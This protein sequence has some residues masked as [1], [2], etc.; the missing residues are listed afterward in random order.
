MLESMNPL[1]S[2]YYVNF[3]TF[4]GNWMYYG[5]PIAE[6]GTDYPYRALIAQIALGANPT[7]VAI[8]PGVTDDSQNQQLSGNYKYKLHFDEGMLPP[9]KKPGFW[10]ITAYGPDTF[11]IP[12]EINRY[13]INDRSNVTYNQDGSLDILLQAEA[14][15]GEMENNW[16]PVGTRNFHLIM[17]LYLPDMDQ[18][19]GTWK[20]PE[21]V[22]Q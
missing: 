21:I 10:S 9:V 7:Y 16:L 15:A 6:W 4:M 3:S 12:N 19:N 22:K 17:R 14:P 8:Y 20:I 5:D 2:D 1:L 18:I 11:L 13:C